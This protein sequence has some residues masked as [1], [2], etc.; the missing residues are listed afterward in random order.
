MW[1]CAHE[2]SCCTNICLFVYFIFFIYIY[3]SSL[4]YI[5]RMFQAHGGGLFN[6]SKVNRRELKWKKIMDGIRQ[7]SVLFPSRNL[8]SERER[9]WKCKGKNQNNIK[10]YIVF[11]LF[12]IFTLIIP[13]ILW[14]TCFIPN[15]FLQ[16]ARSEVI[17]TIVL[18]QALLTSTSSLMN[19]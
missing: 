10:L 8:Q 1:S 2:D 14:P 17:C 18:K 12:L 15:F 3:I 13:D 6:Y 5:V 16:R 19:C 7:I 9:E 11:P 4:H